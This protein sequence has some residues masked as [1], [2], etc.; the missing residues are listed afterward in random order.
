[1]DTVS[2][3]SIATVAVALVVGCAIIVSLILIAYNTSKIRREL[4]EI[5]ALHAHENRP[6]S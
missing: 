5:R 4:D 2:V 6:V 1:M 3:I